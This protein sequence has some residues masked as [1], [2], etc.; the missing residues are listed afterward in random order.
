[1]VILTR[2]KTGWMAMSGVIFHIEIR[3]KYS[4][5]D[6]LPF[7]YFIVIDYLFIQLVENGCSYRCVH[8]LHKTMI[9]L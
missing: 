3:S 7:N 4:E 1:M 9:K 6:N 8:W 5:G 2:P